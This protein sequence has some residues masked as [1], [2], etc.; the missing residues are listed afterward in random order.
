MY[1]EYQHTIFSLSSQFKINW[2]ILYIYLNLLSD[3]MFSISFCSSRESI[4]AKYPPN[5]NKTN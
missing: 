5:G 3:L 4:S 2:L 1:A